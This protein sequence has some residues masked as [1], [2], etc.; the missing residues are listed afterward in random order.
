MSQIITRPRKWG[1][2]VVFFE[3]NRAVLLKD[4]SQ[5]QCGE[6][7]RHFL[8]P[9]FEIFTPLNC[10]GFSTCGLTLVTVSPT[11]VAVAAVGTVVGVMVGAVTGVA[12][13]A[14]RAVSVVASV[15]IAV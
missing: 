11:T 3:R 5:V 2:I 12:K 1:V 14:D 10:Y 4:M 15:A 6:V 7:K 13:E 9:S 8:L